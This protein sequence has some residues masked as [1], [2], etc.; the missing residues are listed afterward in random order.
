MEDSAALV[1]F[2]A[3][4]D[5][6]RAQRFYGEVIGLTLHDERPYA[7]VAAAGGATLRITAVEAVAAAP[8]TV[9]GWTVPDLNAAVDDLASRGVGFHRYEGMGQDERGV[10]TAPSG[11]RVAWFNDPDGNTL[12]MTQ[13]P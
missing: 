12:S 2:V 6:D 10:W 9:L 11:A 5:L 13:L 8:Y 3:V 4:T 1:A 7:L